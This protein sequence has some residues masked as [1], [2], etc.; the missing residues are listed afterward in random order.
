MRKSYALW[1][2][3]FMASIGL[4]EAKGQTVIDA[5]FRPRAEYREGFRKPLA[6]TL[7]ANFG[8]VQRTRLNFDY[9]SAL[10]SARLSL[11]DAHVWGSSDTKTNASLLSFYEAW[12]EYLYLPGASVKFGRQPL[13]YDDQRLLA[14]PEWSATGISHDVMVL[15]YKAP[16][17]QAHGGLAYNNAK[18]TVVD[19]AYSYAAVKMYKTMGYGWAQQAICKG[20]TL[21]AI[22]IVEGFESITNYETDYGRATYGGNLVYSND[23]SAWAATLTGYYQQGKDMTKVAGK[24][25][26]DLKA[27]FFAAKVSYKFLKKYAVNL[28]G[29][30]YSGSSATIAA[31]RSNSFNRLYGAVHSYNGSMEYFS[32]LPT[33]GLVDYYGGIKAKLTPKLTADLAGHLFKFDHTFYYKKVAQSKSLGSE[34]DFSLNYAVS[35]EFSLQGGYSRYFNSS[36]TKKYYKMD[37]VDTHPQQWAYVMV[38]IRPQFYKTPVVAEK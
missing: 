10:L 34:L 13:K 9:K 14:A 21:S 32:K 8:V 22:A 12:A 27:S 33:Q 37:G 15:K 2:V 17:F 36:S 7:N 24:G 35:K 25:Y 26:A 5:E 28:G 38:T 16:K 11:Q 31:D 19:V 29:D 20:T 18:D 6:D 23:S 1:V 4:F 3:I 30:Y